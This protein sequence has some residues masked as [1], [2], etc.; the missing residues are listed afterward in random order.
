MPVCRAALPT[1]LKQF[2]CP[3][4]RAVPL[5]TAISTWRTG[6]AQSGL[7]VLGHRRSRASV[8]CST[9]FLSGFAYFW[10]GPPPL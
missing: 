2:F 5:G 9:G 7:G 1:L 10:H 8:A 4:F 3:Q 6:A